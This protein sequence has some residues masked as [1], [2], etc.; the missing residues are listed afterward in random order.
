MLSKSE[1]Y[2]IKFNR[3]VKI[4]NSTFINAVNFILRE[5]GANK[6]IIKNYNIAF[7]IKPDVNMQ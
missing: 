1:K 2:Y 5:S 4:Y 6:D 7:S 3:N